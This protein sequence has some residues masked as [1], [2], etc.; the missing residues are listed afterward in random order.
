MQVFQAKQSRVKYPKPTGYRRLVETSNY[1]TSKGEAKGYLTGIMYLAPAKMSGVMNTCVM[2]TDGP[3]GCI[4]LCLNL[5]G[6]GQ[7]TPA[8]EARIDKTLLLHKDRELFLACLRWDIE[9]LLRKAKRKGMKL[10]VR[11]NGTSDLPWIAVQMASEYPEVIF[12]DYTKLPQPE[13]RMRP[14]YRIVFSHSGRNLEETLRVMA[15]GVNVAVVFNRSKGEALPETWNGRPVI[16][17][18]LNDLRFLDPVGVVVGL[19]P[20]G[21]RALKAAKAGNS[22]F[23]VLA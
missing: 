9:R 17:G 8:Q 14:N 16:D 11:I 10:C 2:A 15:L 13:L 20:K 23:I 21:P 18:D 5:S 7:F 12:Y 22:P 6:Q 4:N 3:F 1:K 19:R